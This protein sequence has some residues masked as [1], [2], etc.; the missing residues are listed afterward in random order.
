MI[1]RSSFLLAAVSAIA[2]VAPGFAQTVP[3]TPSQPAQSAEQ[4]PP[5][6]Q[7][8]IAATGP[9]S[10][11]REALVKAYNG[12]PTLSGARAQ[13]RATDENVPIARAPGL[14]SIGSTVDFENNLTSDANS[15]ASPDRTL[16]AGVNLTVPLYQGGLVRNSVRAAERRVLAAREGLRGTESD[17]FTDVVSVYM[18]VIRDESIV[19][20]NQQNVRVLEVNL[21][22]TQDRFEVGDLTRTDVAQSEARLAIARGQLRSAEA[23]LI[24][25]RENYVRLVGDAPGT[26][27]PPPPLPNLPAAP[28]PAVEVALA[29]NPN[30]GA[31][32]RSAEA[33]RYDVGV[34]RS[35]RLP[36]ISAIAGGNYTNY[37]GSLGDDTNA[38]I[39]QSGTAATAGLSLTLPLFQG[40]EPA[41]RVRQ[42]QALESQ[43]IEQTTETERAVIANVRA[44]YSGWRS[45]LAV[46]E[47][48]Q[49][50][51]DAN[52]LSLE[53]VRAENS[54]GNRTI[55]DILNAEQELLNSQ[56]TLVTAR[57]DAYVAGFALLA[58]MGRAEAQDLG[59]DGGPLYDPVANYN[60]VR[61]RI[62]DWGDDPTPTAIAP[63]T[64]GSRAQTAIVG[65]LED[66][67]LD[68]PVDTGPYDPAVTTTP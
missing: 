66:P 33:S 29:E 35:S 3:P 49:V 27:E 61:G 9:L 53:G 37:L 25:S 59:L 43:A 32:R 48:S 41:A 40:G 38:N 21:Q 4:V 7:A 20:L 16:R 55:L 65:P 62:W 24:S 5:P 26:L 56:V 46:I 44:A 22:A 8:Q 51:V 23:G 13:L 36:R 15:L 30:L 2:L 11:L 57:R 68:R 34:A 10:T 17:L 42:A 60:R 58:A 45:A 19:Q 52:R 39:G 50:A 18:D 28:E 67:A 1:Q 12:N 31:A 6:S 54:V 14:P 47:S 63:P 64:T